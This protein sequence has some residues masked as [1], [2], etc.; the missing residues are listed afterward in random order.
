MNAARSSEELAVVLK[1]KAWARVNSESFNL[2]M[3][4]LV[5]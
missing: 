1:E 2:V 3:V 4:W 5:E